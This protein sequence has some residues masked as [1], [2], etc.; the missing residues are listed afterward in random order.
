MIH[1][2]HIV[3]N[4]FGNRIIMVPDYIQLAQFLHL[5]LLFI[6]IVLINIYH[7]KQFEHM[8]EAK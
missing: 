8:Q 5:N 6:P 3:Q 1:I 7:Q 2:T 4:L